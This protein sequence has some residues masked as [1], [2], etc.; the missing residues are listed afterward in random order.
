MAC[1]VGSGAEG[2]YVLADAAE[3]ADGR[4]GHDRLNALASNP[5]GVDGEFKYVVGS[6]SAVPP[7]CPL[8]P[9]PPGWCGQWTRPS[10]PALPED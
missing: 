6:M 10:A 9:S 1:P 4:C 2:N 5:D 8:Q 3:A 7:V